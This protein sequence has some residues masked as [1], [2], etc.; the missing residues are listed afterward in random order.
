MTAQEEQASERAERRRE[1]RIK[2]PAVN[3]CW[4]LYPAKSYREVLIL[5]FKV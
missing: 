1:Q 3:S 5:D 4:A 2:G